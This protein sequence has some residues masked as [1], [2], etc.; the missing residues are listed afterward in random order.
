VVTPGYSEALG[1]RL[2]AGRFL[3]D[4]DLTSGVQAMV[5]NEQFVKTF[6]ADVQPVGFRLP[7]VMTTDKRQAEVVG[8]VANVL[9][10]SV[11]QQPTAEIYIA[12]V[13]GA[14]IRRSVN[15]VIR[16]EDDPS[17]YGDAIR[18]LATSLRSDAAA[19]RVA[20]L[21]TQL[22]DSVAQPRFAALVLA[23]FAAL[24]LALAA[25][26]LYGVLAYTVARRRR[27]IGVRSALGASRAQLIAM[28]MR[29]AIAVVA[30]GLAAGMVLSA[31]L[32]R[33]MQ[34]LLVGVTPLDPVSFAAAPLALIAV[35]VIASL[36]PARRAANTDPALALRLE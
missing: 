21:A 2:R 10:D 31:A 19:D 24:A 15:L 23:A 12:P 18:Q 36:I 4:A 6:L 26:G 7:S 16:T 35:C 13:H 34:A 27:E 32:T 3:N 8:V 29:E 11:D 5:V 17:A 1:V 20:P 22:S 30:C 9:K 14:A 33:L 25:V 28:V